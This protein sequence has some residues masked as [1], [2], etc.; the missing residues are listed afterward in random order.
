VLRSFAS[1]AFKKWG[2][3]RLKIVFNFLV[4]ILIKK[5]LKGGKGYG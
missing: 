3:K 2:A 1:G 5:L 4:F